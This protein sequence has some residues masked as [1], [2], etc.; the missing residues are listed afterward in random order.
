VKPGVNKFIVFWLPVIGY[1][2][3][4]FILSSM[5]QPF[6]AEM[7]IP[8]LDKLL[9]AVEYGIL[10]YLLIRAFRG[11]R[12]KLAKRTL[13]VTVVAISTLYAVTDEFHQV[14]VPGRYADIF[15]LLADFVG[16]LIVGF[17]RR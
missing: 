13:I 9:H 7:E 12:I 1:C 17:M 14:F 15:D 6:P 8:Y 10:S 16:A 3:I 11:T 4:I 5:P 2:A